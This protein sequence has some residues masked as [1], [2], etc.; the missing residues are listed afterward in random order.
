MK[1]S[2]IIINHNTPDLVYNCVRSI[3]KYLHNI[4]YEIIVVDNGSKEGLRV[5]DLGLGKVLPTADCQLLALK[6]NLGFGKG[7]NLGAKK[8]KGQYLWFLNSDTL[9]ID[10]SI[11]K[12]LDFL[13]QKKEIGI[14]SPILYNDIECK[15][16]QPFFF[17]K[18]Q[19][20]SNLIIRRNRP[21][22]IDPSTGEEFFETDVVVGASLFIKKEIFDKV[23]G[24][25]K[26][27]F[28]FFEDDDLCFRVKKLGFR[29][30]VY[31]RSKIV[32]LQGKSINKNSSRKTLYYQSQA[33]F[34]NKHYGFFPTLIMRILRWPYKLIKTHI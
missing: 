20:L 16:I 33:Y 17:A 2:I 7:N 27:I 34:W 25:D 4:S 5:Q 24:F 30:V 9:L 13:D 6:E 26:N 29:V 10:S 11:E 21:K 12:L 31:C 19:S 1:L 22:M 18:F 28:M 14:A 32:H 3:K 23:G 15:K 8:A